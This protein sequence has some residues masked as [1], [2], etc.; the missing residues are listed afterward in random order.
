VT[1]GEK[2]VDT[3]YVTDLTNAKITDAAR[4]DVIKKRLADVFS[5]PNVTAAAAAAS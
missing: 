3:F 4:H 2:A 1:Y 5:G